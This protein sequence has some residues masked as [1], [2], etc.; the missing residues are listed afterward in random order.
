M[1]RFLQQYADVKISDVI[2]SNVPVYNDGS[3]VLSFE[4]D[5]IHIQDNVLKIYFSIEDVD[6]KSKI[7]GDM[8][9][10][11]IKQ[12]ME[13]QNSIDV[14]QKINVSTECSSYGI[15]PL[16]KGLLSAKYSDTHK[17]LSLKDGRLNISLIPRGFVNGVKPEDT[18]KKVDELY[19]LAIMDGYDVKDK[20]KPFI[21]MDVLS[22]DT[23]GRFSYHDIGSTN[24]FLKELG[25]LQQKHNGDLLSGE[26]Q[27]LFVA[28]NDDLQQDIKKDMGIF[29]KSLS[30]LTGTA[31]KDLFTNINKN[32]DIYRG[33]TVSAMNDIAYRMDNKG[34]SVNKSNKDGVLHN[35]VNDKTPTNDPAKPMAINKTELKHV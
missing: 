8:V 20:N 2:L 31:K 24:S 12:V 35:V 19:H 25:K 33:I 29:D 7:N 15:D 27:K 26:Q 10:D 11:V 18:A 21:N 1:T 4:K 3:K 6:V 32:N 5:A 22:N 13:Y 9:C 16:L 17:C 14:N 23:F 28:F 30:F 34:A